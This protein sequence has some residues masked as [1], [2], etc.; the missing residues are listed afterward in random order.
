[1]DEII[2]SITTEVRNTEKE[3]NVKKAISNIFGEINPTINIGS[4]FKKLEVELKGKEAL[5]RFRDLLK[6]DQIRT[7]SRK[8]LFKGI[9]E[10]RILFF[11]NKQVA[12]A[13]HISFSEEA[14]ESPL[15]PIRIEIKSE[16]PKSLI[17]WLAPKKIRLEINKWLWK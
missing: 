15:G 1:M 8:A 11:L 2:I 5:F 17:N 4:N 9:M 14:S 7:A 3:E 6:L 13:N 10:K 16:N 12:F